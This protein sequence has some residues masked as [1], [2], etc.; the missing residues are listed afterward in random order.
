MPWKKCLR[1]Q[2]ISLPCPPMRRIAV[3]LISALSISI[4]PAISAIAPKA[5]ASCAK[6]GITST[7]QGKRFTC[8][9]KG[10][11]LVWDG[12]VLV[13]QAAPVTSPQPA[14]SP[15]NTPSPTSAPTLNIGKENSSQTSGSNPSPAPNSIPSVSPSPTESK[16]VD[17]QENLTEKP[18]SPIGTERTTI[19]IFVCVQTQ[20]LGTIWIRKGNENLYKIVGT[21]TPGSTPSPTATSPNSERKYQNQPCDKPGSSLRDGSDLYKCNLS[22]ASELKWKW[23]SGPIDKTADSYEGKACT[24]S[25]E[26]LQ[27]KDS[28]YRCLADGTVVSKWNYLDT[29]VYDSRL[30]D[31]CS[32]PGETIKLS[33]GFLRCET[34]YADVLVLKFHPNPPQPT[35]NASKY[36]GKAIQGGPCDLSGDTFDI[37]NGYLE[38]RYVNGNKLQWVKL[39]TTRALF[40]NPSSPQGVETCR[41]KNADV[42]YASWRL[43]GMQAGFPLVARSGMNN[44]GENNVLM[45]GM[46]FPEFQGGLTLKETLATDKQVYTDWFNFFTNGKVKMNV[47]TI[48]HWVRSSRAAKDYRDYEV[49]RLAFSQ[50]AIDD[51]VRYTA[52]PLIDEI[53][54]EIDLRKF[55][56]VYI[57]FPPGESNFKVNLIIRSGTFKIKEGGSINLNLFA[58]NTDLETMRR[59][60]WYFDIHESLH[61]FP[62]P[63]HAP[64]NGWIE[65]EATFA[66]NSWNRFIMNWLNDDQVYCVEKS[67]LQPVEIKLSPVERED[68][69][70]KMA[71]IKISPTKAIVVQAHGIDK[72]SSFNVADKSF[73]PG[74]Y[75]IVAYLVNLEDS[76]AINFGTDGRAT[77][78]DNGNDPAYPKWAYYMPIDGTTTYKADF[79]D[80][81]VMRNLDFS[82]YVAGVGDVYKIEG[83]KI[84][85]VSTGD[86]ETIRISLD[87]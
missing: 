73:A 50:S 80:F 6:S 5:G 41:L 33:N 36:V 11:T 70:T 3:A 17:N 14:I 21:S 7:Y 34:V 65:E 74:F 43:P 15:S 27:V 20:D 52:Q 68:L 71:T 58:W 64:G 69:L 57:F 26:I 59:T 82:K 46:D 78:N 72:W 1:E 12:G 63:L 56:T 48:D 86:Y 28:S 53:S 66:L 19:Y 8:I 40:T 29:N 83:V 49:N 13:K 54:K 31:A 47:T 25:L 87:K 24:K 30:G 37:L 9:K 62:L 23:I 84:E 22:Q 10:K 42:P 76:G 39:N 4:F 75:G 60:H 81:G 44:P 67:S 79:F 77:T 45:V 35:K 85:F 51:N 38:C 16:Q 55:S 18:C 61:D 32:T 2:P